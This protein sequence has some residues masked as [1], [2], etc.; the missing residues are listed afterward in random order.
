MPLRQYWTLLRQYLRSQWRKLLVLALLL[1][2]DIGLQ[3]INP[4]LLRSFLDTARAGGAV[5]RLSLAAG[6]FLGGALAAYLLAIAATAVGEDVGWAA[7]TA[8]R[9]DLVAHCLRLDLGFHHAHTPG[10]LSERVDGDVQ[11]LAHLFS[12]LV[13]QSVA[14]CSSSSASWSRCGALTGAWEQPSRSSWALPC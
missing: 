7:T 4:Q 11:A 14:T 12:R 13:L 10:E 3:L 5:Q 6:L 2:G 9:A 8:L 1:G